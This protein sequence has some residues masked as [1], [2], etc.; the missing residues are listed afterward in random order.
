[1]GQLNTITLE[2]GCVTCL[3]HITSTLHAPI[4]WRHYYT[5]LYHEY[6]RPQNSL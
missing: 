5:A 4:P 2:G 1:M 6:P 3:L